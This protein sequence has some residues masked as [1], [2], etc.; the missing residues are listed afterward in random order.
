M[1][2]RSDWEQRLSRG[3]YQQHSEARVD[4][5]LNLII[6]FAIVVA[7]AGAA[8]ARDFE[9]GGDSSYQNSIMAPEPGAHR[10]L[11]STKPLSPQTFHHRFRYAH[12][13]SGSVLST[14]LPKTQALPLVGSSMS[15][16]KPTTTI[17]EQGPTIL[18]NGSTVP[19]LPHGQETF[20]DRAS[21]CAHQQGLNNIPGS[22]SNQY[23]TACLQ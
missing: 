2:Q 3:V 15:Q 11:R 9:M 20:Q 18:P 8:Q 14:P 22:A 5:K 17:T 10:P 4:G 19:N 16:V 13:S 7:F 21:R 23:M 1:R 12:G 6:G